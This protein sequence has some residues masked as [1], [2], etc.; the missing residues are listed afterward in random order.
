MCVLKSFLKN[1]WFWFLPFAMYAE[2][3]QFTHLPIDKVWSGHSVNFDVFTAA[4]YQY[5][6]YYDAE[7]NMSIAQ[8]KLSETIWH[9]K[10]L[11]SVLGWD[12]HNYVTVMVDSA[13]LIHIS[14][15]MHVNPGSVEKSRGNICFFLQP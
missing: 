5:V 15:N 2:S 1:V 9:K 10:I 13:G 6:V 14:G 4:P 3:Y 11:P 12:S 7:R 8:R